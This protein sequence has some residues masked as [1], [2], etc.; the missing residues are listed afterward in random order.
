MKAPF[1]FNV[2]W[3]VQ[4]GLIL[5]KCIDMITWPWWKVFMIFEIYLILLFLV[6]FGHAMKEQGKKQ[7]KKEEKILE[8]IRNA[9]FDDLK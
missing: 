4:A 1:I 3:A 2:G 6:A 7:K 5:L 9:N 8:T